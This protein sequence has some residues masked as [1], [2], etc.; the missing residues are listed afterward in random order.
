MLNNKRKQTHSASRTRFRIPN[1]EPRER[2]SHG[3]GNN[4]KN[5]GKKKQR[6][7]RMALHRSSCQLARGLVRVTVLTPFRYKRFTTATVRYK[8][9]TIR[10]GQG[11]GASRGS[12]VRNA[13]SHQSSNGC[14]VKTTE[15]TTTTATWDEVSSSGRLLPCCRLLLP[16]HNPYFCHV[17]IPTFDT[18]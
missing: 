16:R 15:A 5:I 1:S 13:N 4:L 10:E 2:Q 3:A 7:R 6:R 17:T 8:W 18:T 12:A 9:I 11:V 14:Q